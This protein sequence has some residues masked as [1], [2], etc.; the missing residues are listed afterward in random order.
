MT[1]ESIDRI[2]P[3]PFEPK[4]TLEPYNFI[5]ELIPYPKLFQKTKTL[6]FHRHEV[7]DHNYSSSKATIQ[8]MK[9]VLKTVDSPP[10]KTYE[11]Q[12]QQTQEQLQIFSMETSSSTQNK[13]PTKRGSFTEEEKLLFEEGLKKLGRNWTAISKNFVKTRTRRQ[14]GN[15]A[16]KYFDD[17]QLEE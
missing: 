10:K 5:K 11:T 13:K 3:E 12:K 17:N 7:H 2:K 14:V 16:R 1:M 15:Y 4:V 8:D 9:I 6:L